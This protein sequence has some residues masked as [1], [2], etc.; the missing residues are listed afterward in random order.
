VTPPFRTKRIYDPA[1][2][3]DGTR[4]LIMRLWP[5]GIRKDRISIWLKELG[6]IPSLL[7]DFLDKRITWDEYVPRYLACLERP[8]AQTQLA[9]VRDL[10]RA[11]AVT[12]L[13]GCADEMHCHRSLLKAY[14]LNSA[15]DSPNH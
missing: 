12:L 6:P 13:C 15:V 3:E 5:R 4:V 9:Q 14:L 10:A 11:G 2:P 1:G 7:R 8:E